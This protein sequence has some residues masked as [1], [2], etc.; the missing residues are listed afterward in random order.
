MSVEIHGSIFIKDH[1]LEKELV[2][3]SKQSDDCIVMKLD[4]KT[5]IFLESIDLTREMLEKWVA[6]FNKLVTVKIDQGE[7]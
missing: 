4:W 1:D 5:S 7:K 6:D 3:I 2:S